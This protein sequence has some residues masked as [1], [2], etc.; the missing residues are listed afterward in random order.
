MIGQLRRRLLPALQSIRPESQEVTALARGAGVAFL[1]QVAGAGLAYLLQLLLARWM[2]ARDFGEYTFTVGWSMIA[3]VLTGMGLAT[4]VLRFVPAYESHGDR[5]RLSGLLRMSML[6]TCLAGVGLAA[7]GSAILLY[8]HAHNATDG[9]NVL[10]GLWMV[11]LFSIMT[12]QQEA[13]R[14]FRRIGLAYAPSLVLRPVLVIVGAGL[15]MGMGMTLQSTQALA[16]TVA[17]L[18]LAVVLQAVRFWRQLEEPLRTAKPKY[19]VRRWLRT[20]LPLLLVSSFVVILLQTDVVMVGAIEGP[21][22]AGLYGAAAKTA[23]LVGLVLIAVSA[24]GAPIFSALFAQQ[25]HE[26]LQ[27]LV[28]ALAHWVFWPSLA[29]SLFLALFA[30]PVL[31]L[32]GT[33]FTAASTVLTILLVGQVINAGAGAVGW[34]ML[35]TGHQDQAAWAYGWVAALHVV[36]LGV[37]TPLLGTNGAAL[38]TT[39]SYLLWNVWLYALVV[40]LL[41]LHPSILYGFGKGRSRPGTLP[42]G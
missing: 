40:R 9:W 23:S 1:V 31:G 36:L 24:I 15:L 41:D 8:L 42:E 18:V 5:E 26:D 12:L 30:K 7:L 29:I 38:A 20:A 25:R 2:G 13:A 28:S 16:I 19:E 22:A 35:V 27:R 39:T 34:L 6:A 37:L 32:F 10:F 3:A 11:P 17:A 4:A 14:A 21:R 33:E